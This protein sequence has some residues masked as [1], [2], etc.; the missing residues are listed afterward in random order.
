M[1]DVLLVVVND[2]DIVPDVVVRIVGDMKMDG[3]QCQVNR[4][5]WA[6]KNK[7]GDR[8][9]AVVDVEK[10]VGETVRHTAYGNV[11]D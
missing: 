5:V 4:I 2:I 3:L 11:F 6:E 7:T 9:G 1:V 8:T 10:G